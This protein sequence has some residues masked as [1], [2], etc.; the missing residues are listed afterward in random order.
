MACIV[1]D[2]S[3]AADRIRL[4]STT[5]S[6]LASAGGLSFVVNNAGTNV[7][8]P[9]V[10]YTEAEY[11]TV[12]A[13]NLESCFYISQLLYPQLKAAAARRGLASAIVNMS[14]VSGGPSVT[15]TGSIYAASKAA[16]DHLTRYTACEWGADGIRVNSVAPWYIETPL[17]CRKPRKHTDVK[18]IGSFHVSRHSFALDFSFCHQVKGV[19]ANTTYR[20][21]VLKRTPM[22]RVGCPAEVAKVAAFLGS[23][24]ASYVTGQV[25]AVD[26]GFT[27]S[28]FGFYED[29]KIP[30]PQPAQSASKL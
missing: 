10:A 5:E 13:T 24:A 15:Q 2:V 20:D 30:S 26:G 28:G 4:A 27:S 19:L 22:R 11:H 23:D 21:A 16:M 8:K 9:T 3:I 12:M 14:S 7:R 29:F 6:L 25:I 1:A 17:V 18:K